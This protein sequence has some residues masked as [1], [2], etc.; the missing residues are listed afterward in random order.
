MLKS[1]RYETESAAETWNE[2]SAAQIKTRAALYRVA[3]RN[4]DERQRLLAIIEGQEQLEQALKD[5]RAGY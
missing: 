5:L 4:D 1:L 2:A 3:V